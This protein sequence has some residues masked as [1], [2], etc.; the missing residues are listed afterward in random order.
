PASQALT[1]TVKE[2]GADVTAPLIVATPLN[3]VSARPAGSPVWLNVSPVVPLSLS[4]AVTV[5]AAIGSEY[6]AVRLLI[7]P[8]LGVSFTAFTVSDTVAFDEVSVP[9]DAR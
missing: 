8:T 6:T 2:P 4:E 9:S 3:E 5:I 1:V 7:A